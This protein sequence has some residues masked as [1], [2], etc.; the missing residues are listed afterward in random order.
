VHR[1]LR[2]DGKLGRSRGQVNAL[3][4]LIY[5]QDS[6][7]KQQFLVDTGAAVSVLPHNFSLLPS[8]PLLSGADG[9]PISAWGTVSKKLNFGLHTFVVS[10]IRFQT[11]SGYGF[12][13]ILLPGL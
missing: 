2:L 5:L 10:F 1:P 4:S 7:S 3:G 6:S 13:V 12:F 8:G 9:K 11:Y